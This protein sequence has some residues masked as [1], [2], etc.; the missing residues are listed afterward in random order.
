MLQFDEVQTGVGRTGKLYCHEWSGVEPDI[1]S[2]A[3]GLG[4]GFPIGATMATEKIA[5][6]MGPGTHGSTFGGNPLA[7]ACANAV[8]DLVLSEGFL[9]HVN[10]IAK[11]L[12][13]GLENLVAKYPSQ[14]VEVRGK[15]LL[16]GLQCRGNGAEAGRLVTKTNALGLLCV[17]AANN[18]LRML[19]PLIIEEKHVNEALGIF[20]EALAQISAGEINDS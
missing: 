7:M 5:S 1:L 18:V 16:I 9:D 10:M 20:D 3:K 4:G 19:P 17:P 13:S 15:G 6:T 8:L 12:W 2:S 14:L 11:Q